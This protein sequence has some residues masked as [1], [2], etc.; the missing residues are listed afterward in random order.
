ME[1][2]PLSSG[3]LERR[4]G[5]WKWWICS[6]LFLATV[7]NYFDRN[8]MSMLIGK[9]YQKSEIPEI[10]VLADGT[11]K[12]SPAEQGPEHTISYDF[13][14]SNEDYG[15]I[16]RAFRWPYALV[17]VFGG[18]VADRYSI[19]W[20]YALSVGLW[21]LA[22]AA[23][24][25]TWGKSSLAVTRALLGVGEA[26]N[27]PCPCGSWAICCQRG[28]APWASASSAVAPRSPRPPPR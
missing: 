9:G 22:G 26:F 14:L 19:R 24:A 20:V 5:M 13:Q 25:F 8:T 27:W 12:V 18:W 11:T 28:T 23:A 6:I 15:Q 2:Q 7:L 3:T 17:Q 4:S 16:Q 21:S 10:E 1:V